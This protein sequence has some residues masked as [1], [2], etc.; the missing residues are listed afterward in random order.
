MHKFYLLLVFLISFTAFSFSQNESGSI[1]FVLRYGHTKIEPG[2]KYFSSFN[3][4]SLSIETLRFYVSNVTLLKKGKVIYQYKKNVDLIDIEKKLQVFPIPKTVNFDAIRFNIGIDSL[5]NVSGAM[6]GDLDPV[7]GMYWAWQSGYINFKLE[8]KSKV[9]STRNN[10]FQF[11]IGGYLEPFKTIQ[12][13][14]L[15]VKNTT[16]IEIIADIEK[17]INGIDLRNTN[18]I[19]SP[20]KKAV[21]LAKLYKT[22]FSLQE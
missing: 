15:P 13:V 18:E 2:G 17:F 7:N 16:K 3:N 11:H 22:I 12:T 8:G 5:T 10:I 9:C 6:G 4:D 20:G 21:A 19:M 1:T 14:S